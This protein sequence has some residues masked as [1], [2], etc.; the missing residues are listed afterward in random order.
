MSRSA[1][2]L[3]ALALVAVLV[4]GAGLAGCATEPP[5]DRANA[6]EAT[7]NIGAEHLRRGDNDRARVAF[8]RALSYDAD[9]FTANWGMAVISDRTNAVQSAR[10]YFEHALAIR[11]VPAVY[12]S[13]AAFLCRHD[14]PERGVEM[15]RAALESDNPVD[16]AATSANAGLCL[17]RANEPERAVDYF[18]RA[19][20]LDADQP[21][22]L[23][24]M[25]KIAYHERDYMRARAFIERAD[26]AT[27]LAPDELR[28][29][30]RI[31]KALDDPAAA[32]AYMTRYNE[33][34]S[35]APRS[36]SELEQ[37]RP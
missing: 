29:A 3:V 6:A 27:P 31:E 19:L 21:T 34:A 17:A 2:L 35:T 11:D 30:A 23:T 5:V 4:A 10:R 14:Q 13:Y 33:A 1:G 18:R 12:N 20:E 16:R 24:Q 25:A 9:N 37:A 22:A 28:L 7:A 36:S 32:G 26:S 15:F 8:K